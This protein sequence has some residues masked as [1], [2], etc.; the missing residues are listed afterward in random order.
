MD[1]VSEKVNEREIEKEDEIMKDQDL[2]FSY[3]DPFSDDYRD[4]FSRYNFNDR[5]T[6][7]DDK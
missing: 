3:E 7:F 5:M 1:I 6:E 2:I 4:F